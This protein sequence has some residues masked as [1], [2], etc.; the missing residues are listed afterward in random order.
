MRKFL[1][2]IF[3]L[4]ASTLAMANEPITFILPNSVGSATDVMAREVA[5]QL[6]QNHK[7]QVIV[8]NVPGIDQVPG[9]KKFQS[10]KTPA[11]IFGGTTMLVFA[12]ILHP[13][14]VDISDIEVLGMLGTGPSI[15][16]VNPKSKI[17]TAQDLVQAIRSNQTLNIGS[18]YISNRINPLAIVNH[19]ASTNII[20]VPYKAATQ[21]LID[22]MSGLLDVGVIPLNPSL[23]SAITNKQVRAIANTS[24]QDIQLEGLSIPTLTHFTESPQWAGA[25]FVSKNQKIPLPQGIEEKLSAILESEEF[26]QVVRNFKFYPGTGNKNKAQKIVTQYREQLQQI[27]LRTID[28]R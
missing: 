6:Q 12:P 15:W 3:I 26:H 14:N 7:Q 25:V 1:T 5:R 18:D 20:V 23:L 9:L 11:L 22:V 16:V 17:K 10:L 27:D 13:H 8:L 28:Q 21:T 19:Y 4:A 2:S 24:H